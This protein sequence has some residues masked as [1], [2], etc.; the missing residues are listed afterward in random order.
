M[1]PS[2]YNDAVEHGLPG[3]DRSRLV[4][5][6]DAIE[7]LLYRYPAVDPESFRRAVLAAA[8]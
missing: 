1:P 8:R 4:E 5:E 2:P 6:F 3:E 7:P